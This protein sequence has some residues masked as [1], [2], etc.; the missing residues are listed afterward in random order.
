MRFYGN[1]PF[2]LKMF[3]DLGRKKIAFKMLTCLGRKTQTRASIKIYVTLRCIVNVL[4]TTQF[5][6]NGGK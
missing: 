2:S 5:S 3:P 1:L 4:A 6:F